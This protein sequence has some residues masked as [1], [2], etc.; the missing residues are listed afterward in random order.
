MLF[1][2]AFLPRSSGVG[3]FFLAPKFILWST[4]VEAMTTP[5]YHIL[6]ESSI[7]LRVCISKVLRVLSSVIFSLRNHNL[8]LAQ[9]AVSP[10][11]CR[12]L[13]MS[14]R[15]SQNLCAEL[16]FVWVCFRRMCLLVNPKST[17]T[18]IPTKLLVLAPRFKKK[19]LSCITRWNVRAKH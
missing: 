12:L 15:G 18:W 8:A 1:E 14:T 16:I 17:A 13:W 5:S 4:R 6:C 7:G 10:G 9:S 19:T 3:F 2:A 11:H